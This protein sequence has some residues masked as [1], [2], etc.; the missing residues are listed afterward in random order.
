MSSNNFDGI[1][2]G[3]KSRLAL[4]I[5]IIIHMHTN[6]TLSPA[7]CKNNDNYYLLTTVHIRIEVMWTSNPIASIFHFIVL[8]AGFIGKKKYLRFGYIYT[9]TDRRKEKNI[10]KTARFVGLIPFRFGESAEAWSGKIANSRRGIGRSRTRSERSFSLKY[11]PT[12]E[13]CTSK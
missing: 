1:L 3:I 5:I 10:S 7:M 11:E 12:E 9:V 8:T 2:V 6:E 4:Y 13:Y